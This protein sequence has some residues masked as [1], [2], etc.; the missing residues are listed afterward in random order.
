M[1]GSDDD[2]V[3][4]LNEP[5]ENVYVSIRNT[6]DFCFATVYVFSTT[7]SKV[8]LS[9]HFSVMFHARVC[10]DVVPKLNFLLIFRC[11]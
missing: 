10:G 5:N 11:F 3:L 4:L 7:A 9:S 6:K 2:D 8:T 1:L